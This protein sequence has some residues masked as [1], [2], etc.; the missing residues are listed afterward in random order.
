MAT[1]IE[2]SASHRGCM[3]CTVLSVSWNVASAF[4]VSRNG[5]FTFHL[6]YFLNLLFVYERVHKSCRACSI[7][8]T[9]RNDASTFRASK[10]HCANFF[11]KIN[12][13]K[14]EYLGKAGTLY[15]E[16]QVE[17]VWICLGVLVWLRGLG[18]SLYGEGRRLEPGRGRGGYLY[19]EG[20]NDWP[21][22]L[23]GDPL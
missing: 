1:V 15:S 2:R 13:W 6:F 10:P 21:L 17:Q 5:V 18:G 22:A 9:N 8:T 12:P 11:G 19:R 3:R 7:W 16:V 14:L 4:T 20:I 23:N